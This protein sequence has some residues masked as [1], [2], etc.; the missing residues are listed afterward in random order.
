MHR[1][2]EVP[3]SFDQVLRGDGLLPGDAKNCDA[4]YESQPHHPDQ[5][6]AGGPTH[7]YT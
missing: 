5:C 7:H 2:E 6:P 3:Q 1:L 4:Q